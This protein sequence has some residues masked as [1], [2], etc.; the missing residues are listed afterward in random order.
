MLRH[1]S[2][3]QHDT[4]L[5]FVFLCLIPDL[6]LC[7]RGGVVQE[8]SEKLKSSLS[9]GRISSKIA[10]IHLDYCKDFCR[11]LLIC[12]HLISVSHP[13]FIFSSWKINL[14][15]QNSTGESLQEWIVKILPMVM[16]IKSCVRLT[17]EKVSFITMCVAQCAQ[18]VF[19]S[20]EPW[21]QTTIHSSV[22]LILHTLP[23]VRTCSIR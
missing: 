3:S 20:T 16:I 22:P 2:P 8:V 23:I 1:W 9:R 6:F 7:F 13:G 21:H 15:S 12:L 17:S 5:F 10:R 18:S 11:N 19:Y 14:D 4:G